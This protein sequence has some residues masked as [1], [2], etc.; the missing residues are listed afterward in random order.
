MRT[1]YDIPTRL[2]MPYW[3]EVLL[4][5]RRRMLIKESPLKHIPSRDLTY[6]LWVPNAIRKFTIQLGPERNN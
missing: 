1:I 5:V 4:L 3:F 6:D 2:N